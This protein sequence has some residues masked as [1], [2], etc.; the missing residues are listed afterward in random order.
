MM[1]LIDRFFCR[2]H[3]VCFEPCST[4][5]VHGDCDMCVSF[6]QPGRCQ[7]CTRYYEPDR[8]PEIEAD[9]NRLREPPGVDP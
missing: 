6:G 2:R 4:C 1:E 9:F 5:E 7:K 8:L 3:W